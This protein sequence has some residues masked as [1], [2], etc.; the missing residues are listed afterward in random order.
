MAE[1]AKITIAEAEFIVDA[2][3]I[4]P[5]NIHCPGIFVNRIVQGIKE[6]KRIEKVTL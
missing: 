1:A 4:D 3:E 6:E 2:G 5:D